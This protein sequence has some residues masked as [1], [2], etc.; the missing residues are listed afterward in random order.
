MP[1]VKSGGNLALSLLWGYY[2]AAGTMRLVRRGKPKYIE[3]LDENL[4]QSTQDLKTGAKVHLPTRQ[5]H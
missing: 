1:S 3:I 2:S 5:R 4:L